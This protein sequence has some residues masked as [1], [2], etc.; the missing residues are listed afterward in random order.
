MP[1]LTIILIIISVLVI[2]LI[3]LPQLIKGKKTKEVIIFSALLLAGFAH[4]LIQGLGIQ[5][6]SNLEIIAEFIGY[7]R[8]NLGMK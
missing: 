3:E 5:L 8:Q 6:P 4:A 7:I 1:Y 2:A